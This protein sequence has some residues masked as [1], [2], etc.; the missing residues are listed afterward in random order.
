MVWRE[1]CG[2]V[3]AL[4]VRKTSTRDGY[5]AADKPGEC[6]VR[7]GVC[8]VWCVWSSGHAR[9]PSLDYTRTRVIT[10]FKVLQKVAIVLATAAGT[11]LASG[12]S[13]T[14]K[15]QGLSEGHRSGQHGQQHN[16]GLAQWRVG[17][18]GIGTQTNGATVVS[19]SSSA[20]RARLARRA[21]HTRVWPGC[22]RRVEVA[23]R[24]RVIVKLRAVA[25]NQAARTRRTH[26]HHRHPAARTITM[27]TS[28]STMATAN[29]GAGLGAVASVG[30]RRLLAISDLHTDYAD[31]VKFLEALSTVTS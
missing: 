14:F 3:A 17:I 12:G 7:A 22:Q 21:M 2:L 30:G 29:G 27:A 15:H 13:F 19:S 16:D 11:D 1:P 8:G 5:W 4:H 18:L 9:K 20:A 31:N 23:S 10:F 26:H 6:C 25:E 24:A 28:T